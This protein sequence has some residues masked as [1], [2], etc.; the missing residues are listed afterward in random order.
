[1]KKFTLFLSVFLLAVVLKAQTIADFEDLT[2]APNSYNDGSGL[3]GDFTSGNA[4]FANQYDTS[5]FFWSGFAYSNMT[6]DTTPGLGN[7]YSA[8]TGSGYGGSANYAVADEYGNAKVRFT[9]AQA[10]QPI[11]GLFVTNATYAYLSMRDGDAF[12]KK[13]GGPNGTDQDWFMLRVIGWYN[14]ALK[15]NSV[16]FY[17]ADFRSVDSTQDYIVKDWRWLDL[18]PL[19]NLDSIQF[20][21]SSSDTGQFGMNTPA[22]FC[23]DQLS[24]NV[25]PVAANDG[26]LINYLQDTLIDVLAN[27]V[28]ATLTPLTVNVIT[29]PLIPGASAVADASGKIHYT[30]AVGILAVDTF[31][32]NVCDQG[33]LCDTAQVLVYIQ[34]LNGVEESTTSA[35][36]VYPNP[37]NDYLNIGGD[38]AIESI[39][40]IDGTG[41][42]LISEKPAATKVQ[43]GLGNLPAGMYFLKVTSGSQTIIRKVTK[44]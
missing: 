16:D 18:S 10:G 1:M 3:A 6:D 19:G 31:Y 28:D 37:F 23:I 14:G 35:L 22:Y 12:A 44:N 25:A 26:L 9:G 15:Q 42:L 2:L 4:V 40:L 27:D 11:S 39:E 41:R 7:Q 29:Q 8:I 34:G 43:L 30:P 38:I 33:N 20:L 17:L 24:N 32:Y 13:F 36:T 5:F 21:L